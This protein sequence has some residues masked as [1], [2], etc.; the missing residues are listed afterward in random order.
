MA[1]KQAREEYGRVGETPNYS[2]AEHVPRIASSLWHMKKAP[3]AG[4][5]IVDESIAAAEV[6]QTPG[7]ARLYSTSDSED[8]VMRVLTYLY[9]DH[10]GARQGAQ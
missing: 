5:K 1:D 3:T 6:Y 10:G 8:L 7:A 2:E 4:F 9:R